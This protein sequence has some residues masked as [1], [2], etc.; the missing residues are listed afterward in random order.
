MRSTSSDD[1]PLRTVAVKAAAWYGAT[2]LWGQ[3]LSWGVTIV[4]ARLLTPADY[5][6]YAMA[7]SVLLMLELLQEFGLGTAIVQRHDLTRAQ[8]NGIFWIVTG[9]SLV[10]AAATFAAAPLAASFYAEPRLTWTLRILCF[11]FLLNSVGMVPYNLLTKAINLR[12]RSLAEASGAA[13]SA[14]VAFV[15]AWLGFG[16]WA[17]V[18]G[19][20]ARAVVLN[21]S[22]AAFAGW[23]PGLDASFQGMRSVLAF[24]MRVAGMHLISNFSP[25]IT[26]FIV[27]RLLGPASV[28]L[29]SMSQGLADAPHRLSTAIINQ[30]SLPLFSKV[31]ADRAQL[32]RYFF[33]ISRALAV[34]SLPLHVGLIITAPDL[35]SALLSSKWMDMVVPFQIMCV[36]SALVVLTLTASPLLTALG[37]VDI[38]LYRSMLSLGS[39]I[40]A[41]VIGGPFGLATLTFAR[42]VLVLPLRLC[43]LRD[44]LR[45][46]EAPFL[47]Y[48]RHLWSPLIATAAMFTAVVLTHFGLLVTAGP[49][50]RLLVEVPIGSLTYGLALPLLDRGL[51]GELRTIARDLWSRSR[52]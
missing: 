17:L 26:T 51:L 20:L 25:T 18:L 39:M 9:T 23:R 40:A 46:L 45:E 48:I 15:L 19:Y 11:N 44:G 42:V 32:A 6:L 4:L 33:Q 14:I 16:V 3:A 24:G 5:G 35:I 50:E 27:A 47:T 38:L 1:A 30:I 8:I 29:Y 37:R 41:A 52:V 22:L 31:R 10:L 12:H 49:F 36:E 21:G 43:I 28:G 2:R 34:V 7:L 13:A